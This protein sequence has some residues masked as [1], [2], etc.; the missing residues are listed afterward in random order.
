MIKVGGWSVIGRTLGDVWRR[1]VTSVAD[2]PAACNWCLKNAAN[3]GVV[4]RIK[5]EHGKS[6]MSADSPMSSYWLRLHGELLIAWRYSPSLTKKEL[7]RWVIMKIKDSQRP[8]QW[9]IAALAKTILLHWLAGY[10]K[11]TYL[12]SVG[13]HWI[14]SSW[15][16]LLPSNNSIS[17]LSV[18]HF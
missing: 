8:Y 1:Q 2:E 9:K 18:S 5:E 16:F 11:Q 7:C 15:R 14:F 4:S 12:L 3:S 10:A 17:P 6:C 13:T